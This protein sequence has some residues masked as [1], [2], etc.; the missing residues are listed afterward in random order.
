MNV[1]KNKKVW[2]IAVPLIVLL[3]FLIY[4]SLSQPSLKDIPGGFEEVAFAR[5]EQNKGGII[6]VYAVTVND[7]EQAKY[8]E[9]AEL[10]PTND[11]NSVTRIFFFDKNKPYPTALSVEP[12]YYDHEK[13]EA[14]QIIKR[15]GNKN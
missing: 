5:N 7:I 11:Y 3:G 8:S 13:Y 9:A 6:R 12:P 15:T 10:F 1:N 2:L 14:I 4:D